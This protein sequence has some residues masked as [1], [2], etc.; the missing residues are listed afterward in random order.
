[1]LSGP[2]PPRAIFKP[3][4]GGRVLP[5]S[6]CLPRIAR[7]PNRGSADSFSPQ[8][9]RSVGPRLF[10]NLILHVF[11]KRRSRLWGHPFRLQGLAQRTKQVTIE[12]VAFLIFIFTPGSHLLGSYFQTRPMAFW[13]RALES[14]AGF[15]FTKP[16]ATARLGSLRSA[17]AAPL[18]SYFQTRRWRLGQSA[19]IGGW[20]CFYQTVGDRKIGFVAQRGKPPHWVRIFKPPSHLGHGARTGAWVCFYSRRR[21]PKTQRA[22]AASN[23]KKLAQTLAR[24]G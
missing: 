2:T 10:E 3:A 23:Y 9:V 21:I 15:V 14:A 16:S 12:D 7:S 24:Q 4:F 17:A 11:R 20:L 8:G 13:A 19:R 5:V 6:P 1:M 18:G 22:R